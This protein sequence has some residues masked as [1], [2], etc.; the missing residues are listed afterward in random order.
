LKTLVLE[1]GHCNEKDFIEMILNIKGVEDV[2][3]V[4][5]EHL[6]YVKVNRQQVDM[7][8]LQPYLNRQI[9]GE[10]NGARS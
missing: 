8:G 1:T 9:T 3:L 4:D 5:G 7:T 2:L 6:A 10:R